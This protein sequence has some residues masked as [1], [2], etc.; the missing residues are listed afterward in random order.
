MSTT[1]TRFNG[2]LAN[3]DE[4]QRRYIEATE[5]LSERCR[6]IQIL[7]TLW[8]D[9]RERCNMLAEALKFY[10]DQSNY[11]YDLNSHG[12]TVSE[13][14]SDLGAKAREALAA[15]KETE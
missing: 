14:D 5:E 10:A 4:L 15:L 2:A 13:I 12:V 1:D 6:E 11:D 8:K 3:L 9:E 7:K